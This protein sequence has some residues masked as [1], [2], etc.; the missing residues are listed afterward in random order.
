MP[1]YSRFYFWF[2][3]TLLGGFL[4]LAPPG[5]ASAAEPVA[6]WAG[7]SSEK[8]VALTFEDGPSPVYTPKIMALLKKY[9]ACGTFFVVG[10]RVEEHPAL[11][12][13]LIEAGH[14]VGNHSF[15]HPRLTQIAQPSREQ[16]GTHRR[17]PGPPGLHAVGKIVPATL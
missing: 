7:P 12:G 5:P 17:R 10:Y 13:A 16:E 15:S 11:V 8:A 14:E 9:Q 3:L 2:T 4:G 1:R 6:V